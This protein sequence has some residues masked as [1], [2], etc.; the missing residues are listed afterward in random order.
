MARL[1]R[2]ELEPV[3]FPGHYWRVRVCP[4]C[5]SVFYT[6][7][8]SC[9][10]DG[11]PLVEQSVDPL[12]GG[13]IDRYQILELLGQGATGRVYR[14][15]HAT[16]DRS[17]A[18]KVLFGDYAAE[19]KIKERFRREALAMSRLK[20]PNIVTVDDFGTTEEGLMF[21]VQEH[22]PGISLEELIRRH[23]PV[24]PRAAAVI[25]RQIAAGLGAV[26]RHGF[27]HRDV[28]P[29]NVMV[30]G[31]PGL[32]SVKLLD[33][34]AVNLLHVP[35]DARLTRIGYLVGT[36]T[37]MAPE[38]SIDSNVG[39][40]ADLYA[41]GVLLFEMLVGHPPFLGTT[42][43][44]VLL[45]HTSHP[46]PPVPPSGGLEHVV[47][48]LLEKVPSK[49]PTEAALVIELLDRLEFT[50]P[51]DSK[52][53]AETSG[54]V[55][56]RQPSLETEV[57]WSD[58]AKAAATMEPQHVT[59]VGAPLVWSEPQ[60]EHSSAALMAAVE[61]A[62]ASNDTIDE[63]SLL[64]EPAMPDT[65]TR[66]EPVAHGRTLVD[67]H[68]SLIAQP[69][70]SS[71][72]TRPS[73]GEPPP[74]GGATDHRLALGSLGI[75]VGKDAAPSG[76]AP[77]FELPTLLGDERS[78][79]QDPDAR[80]DY[81]PFFD[82]GPTRAGRASAVEPTKPAKGEAGPEIRRA[83][84]SS[85]GITSGFV[86]WLLPLTVGLLLLTLAVLLSAAAVRG[87]LVQFEPATL[88]ERP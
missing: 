43:A 33:F 32:E 10:I 39:P 69:A 37:Y 74:S 18:V 27:V 19:T 34:G 22:V 15:R 63:Q 25:A 85:S 7:V 56:F 70:V 55:A 11:E 48:K 68:T 40:E 47:A 24:S 60:R 73:S 28:K 54:F 16:L 50:A 13:A 86:R 41:L 1:K 14:A 82:D 52:A 67:A 31:E 72:S 29:S 77:T 65:S 58:W 23:S 38:Q 42:R 46:P 44:E 35:Q 57:A 84:L 51:E 62:L 71:V 83:S 88:E 4:R 79:A 80:R 53:D 30:Q 5:R 8:K 36:P 6:G 76:S 59:E 17:Y 78:A 81:P 9:R 3:P 45:Q 21:L 61:D 75:E 26:H 49:R 20:H 66:N 2:F 87:R 64:Y 12:L